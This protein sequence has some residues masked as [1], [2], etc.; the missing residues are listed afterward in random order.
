MFFETTLKTTLLFYGIVFLIIILVFQYSKVFKN[1]LKNNYSN[2]EKAYQNHK[3]LLF[4]NLSNN[5]KSFYLAL[6]KGLMFELQIADYYRNLGYKV[7]NRYM[8]S[9]DGGIDVIARKGSEIILIQC[10]NYNTDKYLNT[11][12]IKKFI[13]DCFVYISQQNL[14]PAKVKLHFVCSC[15]LS[16]DLIPK[17]I[18]FAKNSKLNLSLHTIPY[19]GN[20][21]KYYKVL[22][23][24]L[25]PKFKNK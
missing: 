6:E 18:N 3:N 22:D 7:E 25:I 14:N 11:D 4:S 20:Q 2:R 8:L 9:H 1:T 17:Y 19:L 16:N 24:Y 5:D 12:L 13:G 15:N 21:E 10:K 23:T